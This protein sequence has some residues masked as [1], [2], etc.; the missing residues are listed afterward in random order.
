MPNLPNFVSFVPTEAELEKF[1]H[2]RFAGRCW[3]DASG[4]YLIAVNSING[5][6]HIKIRHRLDYPVS[7]FYIF[8]EIKNF[9]LGDEAQAVQVYPRES[10]L[11]DG[12]NTYHLW[13]WLGIEGVLPN[14][15]K[16]PRYH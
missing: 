14:L 10:D 3:Q 13:S 4:Q 15:K 8:Q 7:D 6:T 12:S 16:L 1:P 11:V 9:V 5:F 2:L